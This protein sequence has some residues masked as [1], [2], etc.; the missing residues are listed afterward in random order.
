MVTPS[1]I[2]ELVIAKLGKAVYRQAETRGVSTNEW[3]GGVLPIDRPDQ[4]I[5]ALARE[6]AMGQRMAADGKVVGEIWIMVHPGSPLDPIQ[7]PGHSPLLR[8]SEASLLRKIAVPDA[9]TI[10]S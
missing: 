3:F 4:A 10:Q 9:A 1:S 5:C 8:G 7:I 2:K 6:I